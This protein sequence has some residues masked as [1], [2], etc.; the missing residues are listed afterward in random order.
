MVPKQKEMD[1]IV[2]TLFEATEKQPHL[3]STLLVLLGDHG[4]NDAGNH[5]GAGPGESSPA[6]VFAS[7]KFQKISHGQPSPTDPK[8]E[9]DFYKKVEQSDVVPSLA[10]LLGFP[11]PKNN[12]GIFIKDFLGLWDGMGLVYSVLRF[13]ADS[14][15]EN[16]S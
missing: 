4:M 6:L 15:R 9:F 11:I 7:P 14:I 13:L 1:G 10:G 8:D 2:E 12:L 5:G 16:A 3:S